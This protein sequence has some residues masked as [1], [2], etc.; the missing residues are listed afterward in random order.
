MKKH[1]L[2]A[3]LA[4]CLAN[5]L[6]FAEGYPPAVNYTPVHPGQPSNPGKPVSQEP[7]NHMAQVVIANFAQIAMNFLQIAGN[8]RDP[9]AIVNGG[10]NI[11]ASIA[12]I[13]QEACKQAKFDNI[14]DDQL[15]EVIYKK[16]LEQNVHEIIG[17]QISKSAL[18][19]T[20]DGK[21]EIT[22]SDDEEQSAS[23]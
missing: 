10:C 5:S 23:V 21:H 8:P 19:H 14:P 15:A 17:K 16:L 12:S 9:V 4:S 11:I 13:A 6:I 22:E 7:E 20:L 2:R 18:K 3:L 1:V